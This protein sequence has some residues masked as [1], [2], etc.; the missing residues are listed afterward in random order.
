MNLG[1]LLEGIDLGGV[2]L[3]GGDGTD[4]TD[5]SGGN[6]GPGGGGGFQALANSLSASDRQRVALR[7]QSVLV[8]P[9]IYKADVLEFCRM[10]VKLKM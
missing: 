8:D 4:G 5:G 10:I 3:P 6:A 7:C 1:S 2:G 9:T